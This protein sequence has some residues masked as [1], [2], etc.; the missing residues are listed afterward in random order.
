[1]TAKSAVPWAER[2]ARSALAG[3][4]ALTT[5]TA[6]CAPIAVLY[7]EPPINEPATVRQMRALCGRC[8]IRA[9][10]AQATGTTGML[11]GHIR[12]QRRVA[13]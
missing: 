5:D 6:A 2:Q 11:A 7:D 10:C 1:V 3:L 12:K 9:A 8:G 13:S 4:P